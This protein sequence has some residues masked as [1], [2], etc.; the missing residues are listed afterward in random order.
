[1]F[2]YPTHIC[3]SPG[4]TCGTCKTPI[5]IDDDFAVTKCPSYPNQV[6]CL[7][8]TDGRLGGGEKNFSVDATPGMFPGSKRA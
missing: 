6:N 4:L 3:K 8:C 5:P 2:K 1:M 7:Q